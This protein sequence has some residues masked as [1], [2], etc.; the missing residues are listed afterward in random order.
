M[1]EINTKN[2]LGK[3]K[4]KTQTVFIC[5]LHFF[6]SQIKITSYSTQ[7][8]NNYLFNLNDFLLSVMIK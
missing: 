1:F 2:I 5:Y 3:D 7:I 6:K 4:K 8:H